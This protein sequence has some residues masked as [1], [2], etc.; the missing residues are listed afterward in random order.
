MHN[1]GE[2]AGHTYGR[3]SKQ[4]DVKGRSNV[5][6]VI[7][8][9]ACNPVSGLPAVLDGLDSQKGQRLAVLEGRVYEEAAA[10]K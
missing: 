10:D 7:R 2:D 9:S 3:T 1:I 5:R 8:R 6:N 4:T